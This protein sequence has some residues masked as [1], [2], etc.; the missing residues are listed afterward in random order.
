MGCDGCCCTSA[1]YSPEKGVRSP[2]FP[3]VITCNSAGL[4]RRRVSSRTLR[5]R[6]EHVRKLPVGERLDGVP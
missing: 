3:T 5:L 1:Q 4:A 6:P 2:M